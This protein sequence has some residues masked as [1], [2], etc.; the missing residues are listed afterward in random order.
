MVCAALI[1]NGMDPM[2]EAGINSHS[3]ILPMDLLMVS[4]NPGNRSI[5]LVVLSIL[6]PRDIEALAS[7]LI[8]WNSR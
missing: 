6:V 4:I 3:F 5:L 7:M 8:P 1:P 2:L